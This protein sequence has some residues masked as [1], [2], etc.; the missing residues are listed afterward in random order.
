MRHS[1]FLHQSFLCVVLPCASA[2]A[3]AQP[4]TEFLIQPYAEIG[5]SDAS[6][7]FSGN[8][9][10]GDFTDKIDNDFHFS[11]TMMKA[12]LAVSW[13][14]LYANVH[15]RTTTD[16]SDV[17][18]LTGS[19]PIKWT[20]NREESGVAVGYK[21][22]PEASVFMGYR[23]SQWDVSGQPTST[24]TFEDDGF[25]IGGSYAINITET[26][27][28]TFSVAHAWLD[29]DI[30]ETVQVFGLPFPLSAS[31]DGTGLK[32]GVAW[33]A[34]L[35]NHWGYSVAAERFDFEFD[36]KGDNNT[37]DLEENDTTIS[38]GLFYVF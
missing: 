1:Q 30:D 3:L 32:F 4:D 21:L 11:A 38:I 13:G 27:S 22:F 14:D 2:S 10:F 36:M 28:L 34:F 26:G 24:A 25:F 16:D 9:T 12:G 7:N 18:I 19:D 29:G 23:T 35:N 6:L 33:R 31:G 20:G 37:L 8:V 17:Q 5:I 15:Y